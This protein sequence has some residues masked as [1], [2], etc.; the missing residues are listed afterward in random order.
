MGAAARPERLLVTD[1]RAELRASRIGAV[2]LPRADG[3]RIRLT[4]FLRV[5]SRPGGSRLEPRAQ[6]AEPLRGDRERH[7]G[8]D[9]ELTA[10]AGAG[11]STLSTERVLDRHWRNLQVLASHNPSVYKHQILGAYELH[12]THPPLSIHF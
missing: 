7:P 3:S 5:H 1:L 12:G 6:P 2:R 8:P 11:G 4:K 10:A 9:A